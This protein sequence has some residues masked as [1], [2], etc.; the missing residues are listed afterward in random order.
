MAEH[1]T[2]ESSEGL[3]GTADESGLTVHEQKAA[4]AGVT[5]V[6][7]AMQRATAL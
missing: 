6:R 3:F 5:G 4:A 2:P 1:D 7:V